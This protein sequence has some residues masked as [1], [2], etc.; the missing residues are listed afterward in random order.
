MYPTPI[1]SL[2]HGENVPLTTWPT[3]LFPADS[4]HP[5]RGIPGPAHVNATWRFR[6]PLAF[7]AASAAFPIKSPLS[8][9]TAHPS[10]ASH[11]VVASSISC[12]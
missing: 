9:F 8:I 12:P 3:S 1:P 5:A 7:N 10:P 6:G 4:A 11:G 2:R